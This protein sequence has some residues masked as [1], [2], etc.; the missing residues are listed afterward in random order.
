MTRNG[1]RK[2]HINPWLKEKWGFER[3]L[4]YISSKFQQDDHKNGE[5]QKRRKNFGI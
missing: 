5:P 3:W 4:D 2:M 1:W